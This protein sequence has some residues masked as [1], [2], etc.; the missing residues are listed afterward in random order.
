VG[1]REL[2]L[3]LIAGLAV[4]AWAIGRY[5]KPGAGAIVLLVLGV[6][7]LADD[8]FGGPFPG[9]WGAGAAAMVGA[10]VT[11]LWDLRRRAG[12]ASP[13]AGRT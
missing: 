5:V 1:E 13:P 3:L 11:R 7:L 9:S 12:G 4:A 10:A 8:Y 6:L 2:G